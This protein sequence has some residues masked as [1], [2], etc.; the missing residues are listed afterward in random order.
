M[1]KAATLLMLAGLATVPVLAA[2][3]AKADKAAAS[4]TAGDRAAKQADARAKRMIQQAL[5]TLQDG[6]E[7]RALGML[8]AI[9]KMFPGSQHRFNAWLE[10]GRAHAAKGRNDEA[11]V[12]LRK[13]TDSP[14]TDVKAES[15]LIQAKVQLAAARDSEAS[16]LLRRITTDYPDSLFANDA[17]FEIGQIHFKAKRWVRAQEAFRRVGTAVPKPVEKANGDVE[18]VAS[19]EPPKRATVN[20][21]VYAEAGQRLYVCVDDRDIA[22]SAALGKKMTVVAK[23]ASGDSETL[24]L[25]PFGADGLSALASVPTTSSPSKPEDGLLTVQGGEVVSVVYVD[26]AS[27]D[28]AKGVALTA[29]VKIVS[30]AV[31]AVM[32]G[33]YRQ[34]VKGVFAGNPAFL[35]LRDLDLDVSPNPDKVKISVTSYR[36]R[37][38]PTADELAEAAANGE[39]IDENADPWIEMA[40]SEVVLTES[41]ARSGVFEGRITPTLNGSDTGDGQIASEADGK[42]VFSYTDKQHLDGTLPR[43][44]TT[45]VAILTGGS[46]E[47]QSIVSSASDP[48]LQSRKLL[49]EA[50]LLNQW[51]TIFKEVGLDAQARSKADEG[52]NRVA[53]IFEL[54]ERQAIQ[55]DVMENAYAAKWDLLLVKGNLNEAIAICRD[56][57]KAYPDTV[58]AD[59]A[60]MRIA[61]AKSES[62]DPKEVEEAARI[63]R[64]VLSMPNSPNKAEAQYLL[65]GI[66]EKAA[67]LRSTADR[68]PD[69][70]AAIAAYRAC[71]ENY[72]QS[73][74]A[75]ES[76]KRVVTYQIEK[77]DYDRA[78][79]TLERVFQDY[80][81]APWLD[82]MLLRWGI[83]CYRKGDVQGATAKFRRVL[84]EYPS[85]SAAGQATSFLQRLQK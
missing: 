14:V 59:V 60:F 31:L 57:L 39:V 25:A 33:A 37:P 23:A 66:L 17:W 45:E 38:K 62:R 65:A 19:S 34:T 28:G 64:S 53:E 32:D 48:V 4:A 30:S 29:P 49:L 70:T 42:L 12:V 79:E 5:T 78:V 50:R 26:E 56:L 43:E 83:V 40:S 3:E 8:E 82:E 21:P 84:E 10:L 68:P 24:E 55:R 16:M 36:K 76:F 47:P 54:A 77:K 67:K 35:R 80:P 1:N 15:Y 72:P 44:V 13:A 63:Y 22:V 61:R 51:A 9:P 74:F 41:A 2:D 6:E 69:Y 7:E 27:A 73:S 46:T 81:D 18:S 20:A 58:L 85:G 52:L 71:A 75:G 11:L